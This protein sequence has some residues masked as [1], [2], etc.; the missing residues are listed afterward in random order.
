MKRKLKVCESK[1]EN[2]KVNSLF[3]NRTE[4]MSIGETAVYLGQAPQTIR[5]WIAARRLPF[6]KIGREHKVLR[7]SL[8]AWIKKQ[9]VSPCL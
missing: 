2:D 4:L 8:A 9:E 7:T 6:V 5:N 1:S 3:E